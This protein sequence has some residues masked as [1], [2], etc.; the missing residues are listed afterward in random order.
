MGSYIRDTCIMHW[1]IYYTHLQSSC[2]LLVDTLSQTSDSCPVFAAVKI[3]QT[4][5]QIDR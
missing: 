5:K 4:N 1:E 3:L 2:K